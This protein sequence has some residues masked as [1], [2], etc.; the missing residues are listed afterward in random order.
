[1]LNI[2]IIVGSTR[3]GRFSEKL[4]PWIQ[5]AV[6]EAGMN[7]EVLDL[8]DHPLP[9][10]KEAGSAAYVQN[11]EYPDPLV[12]AWAEKIKEGDA[13][14]IIAPE[15][16]HGYTAVLKN[17]LDS[18]YGEWNNKP[19]TFVAYGSVGG[20]RAVEQLRQV[21]VELQMAP[22]RAAVHIPAPWNMRDDKGDLK[23][24]ALDGYAHSLTDALTQ[25][26]WWGEALKTARAK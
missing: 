6:T 1:M 4:V 18:I 12:R 8:R 14:I 13:F 24:G 22:I 21:A 17:A 19:V 20:G 11:G 10:Y 5:N 15:Y 25:L 7:P 2:K 26:A 23:E 9:F 3:E 16:N